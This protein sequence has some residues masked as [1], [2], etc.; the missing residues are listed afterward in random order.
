MYYCPGSLVRFPHVVEGLWNSWFV[1]GSVSHFPSA[2]VQWMELGWKQVI[3][4]TGK[5]HYH[6]QERA[7]VNPE[8][9]FLG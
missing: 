1:F 5:M 9:S 6:D 8:V 2:L 4:L 7:M 3:R